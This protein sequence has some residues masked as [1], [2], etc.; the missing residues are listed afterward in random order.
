MKINI[1]TW[2]ISSFKNTLPFQ[3]EYILNVDTWWIAYSDY[4][5]FFDV[6]S[7]SEFEQTDEMISLI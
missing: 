1:K 4:T 5:M 3:N 6:D 2:E 7:K